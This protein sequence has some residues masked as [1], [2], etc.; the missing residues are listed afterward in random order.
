[1]INGVACFQRAINSIITEEQL[2]ATFPYIDNI[3]ICGKDQREHDVNLKHSL[4]AA[5]RR[6]IKYNDSKCVFNSE[7]VDSWFHH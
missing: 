6:Q 5:S 2:Q 7:I 3:M 1:M 4:E